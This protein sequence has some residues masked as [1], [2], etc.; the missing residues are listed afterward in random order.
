MAHLSSIEY[1]YDVLHATT[2]P[3]RHESLYHGQAEDKLFQV[4]AVHKTK[5]WDFRWQFL[6]VAVLVLFSVTSLYKGVNQEVYNVQHY[7]NLFYTDLK[8]CVNLKL[9]SRFAS[10]PRYLTCRKAKRPMLEKLDDLVMSNLLTVQ[11]SSTEIIF[12]NGSSHVL[13]N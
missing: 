1:M 6:Y 12:L 8:S 11:C 4:L 5:R 2:I 13:V 10:S 9:F 7:C 3:V